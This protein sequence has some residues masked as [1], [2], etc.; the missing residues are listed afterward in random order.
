MPN[1]N[2]RRHSVENNDDK[3]SLRIGDLL[4]VAVIYAAMLAALYLYA[5]W[6]TFD[7]NIL[8]FSSLTDVVKVTAY[9]LAGSVPALLLGM[10]FGE[11]L[12]PVSRLEPGAGKTSKVGVFLNKHIRGV[13]AVYAA[14]FLFVVYFPGGPAK[15]A[16]IAT[17]VAVPSAPALASFPI[18]VR[19][20]PQYQARSFLMFLLIGAMG[21]AYM[22]G[23]IDSTRVKSGSTSVAIDV[24][25]WG[26]QLKATKDEP[27]V[28]MGNFG[29]R[30][31]VY[32]RATKNVVVL[33]QKD[34]T[35][36][37]LYEFHQPSPAAPSLKSQPPVSA[38]SAPPTPASTPKI[39][40][41]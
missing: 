21:V 16:L 25:R 33:K 28:F 9:P 15:Y 40:V 1:R 35:V 4:K 3:L 31:F 36:L 39:R 24:A 17:L 41:D 2:I 19:L 34:E 20:I 26:S 12:N 10:I 7:I 30:Y 14:V 32:E 37:A 22:Q 5:Y 27:A 6:G 8:Q 13:A 38:A 11:T 29:D 23:K 18:L